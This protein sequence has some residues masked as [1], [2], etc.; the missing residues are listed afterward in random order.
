MEINGF[1]EFKT[2]KPQKTVKT[3]NRTFVS[4]FKPS[5]KLT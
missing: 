4:F 5:T 3:I 2:F 1:L